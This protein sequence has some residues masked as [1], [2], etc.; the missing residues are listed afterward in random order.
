MKYPTIAP[1]VSWVRI[2]PV[3]KVGLRYRISL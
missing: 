2:M 1:T 3:I